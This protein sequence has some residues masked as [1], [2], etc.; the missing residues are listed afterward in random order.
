MATKSTSLRLDEELLDRVKAEAK[1]EGVSLNFFI[2]DMLAEKLQ[3]IKDYYDA[4]ET[5]KESRGKPIISRGEMARR[6]GLDEV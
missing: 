3:D 5:V 2:A 4:V 6:Y 1:F